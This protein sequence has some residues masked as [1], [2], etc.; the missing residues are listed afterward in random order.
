MG[1]ELVAAFAQ[2]KM[3]IEMQ[4]SLESE[5]ATKFTALSGLLDEEEKR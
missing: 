3:A 4:L 5:A 1:D 2:G